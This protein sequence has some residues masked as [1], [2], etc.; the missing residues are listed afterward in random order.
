MAALPARVTSSGPVPGP[1]ISGATLAD[2]VDHVGR[3]AEISDCTRSRLRI[4]ARELL[5]LD[6]LKRER[7]VLRV[8]VERLRLQGAHSSRLPATV[9]P[10]I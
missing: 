6:A 8:E 5:A 2:V 10:S 7:D 1:P 4:A 9:S 3:C